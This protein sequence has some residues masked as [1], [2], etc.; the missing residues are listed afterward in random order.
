MPRASTVKTEDDV[1]VPKKRAPRKRVVQSDDTDSPVATPRPRVRKPRAAVAKAEVVET[2]PPEVPREPARRAPTPLQAERTSA[3]RSS[4]TLLVATTLMVVISGVGCVVGLSDRGQIDVVAVVNDRNEK[5]QRGEV[6]EG[7]STLT[8]PVQNID[9][10]P[11]GGLV[12][13]QATTPPPVPEVSTATTTATTTAETSGT[14]SSSTE[15]TVDSEAGEAVT[16][17]TNDVETT[18]TESTEAPVPA[19]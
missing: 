10:R 19:V 9:T 8:I 12:P 6:R 3:K 17:D 16:A 5:I 13:S 15:A 7:D 11:N 14:T 1:V 2:T 18:T 4:R